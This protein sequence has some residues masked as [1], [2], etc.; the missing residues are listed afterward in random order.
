MNTVLTDI[1]GF[2]VITGISIGNVS[3]GILDYEKL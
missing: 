3:T 1:L 2:N